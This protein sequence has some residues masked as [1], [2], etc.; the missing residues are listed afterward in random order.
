MSVSLTELK[1]EPLGKHPIFALACVGGC[2]RPDDLA[3]TEQ[4]VGA[5]TVYHSST[6]HVDCLGD[7]ALDPRP[8]VSAMTCVGC[9]GV[10]S[11]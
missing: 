3:E 7:E 2:Y 8:H 11:W 1:D 10:L 9:Y 6:S 5:A 4:E